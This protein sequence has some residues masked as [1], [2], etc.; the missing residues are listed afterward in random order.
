M[1][2]NIF[3]ILAHTSKASVYMV[4]NPS[5][6]DYISFALHI[7]NWMRQECK[8]HTCG[9][10]KFHFLLSFLVDLIWEQTTAK[11]KTQPPEQQKEVK[12]FEVKWYKKKVSVCIKRADVGRGFAIVNQMALFFSLS[13]NST[14]DPTV[15]VF[16]RNT[17]FIDNLPFSFSLR[18]EW[19]PFASFSPFFW[20]IDF[21]IMRY[22]VLIR[23]GRSV[24]LV[25][26]S[27]KR[28]SLFW[29]SWVHFHLYEAGTAR[30]VTENTV[31]VQIYRH[32]RLTFF[33]SKRGC[34]AWMW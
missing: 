20:K 26:W 28:R 19:F 31:K 22:L 5:Y 6:L 33:F 12:T 23:F 29:R 3:L 30:Y 16:K 11:A 15:H 27:S 9:K 25:W 18:L 10:G 17:R 8:E 32:R 2:N 13:R 7:F 21:G 4:H 24:S 34:G 14:I 1:Q